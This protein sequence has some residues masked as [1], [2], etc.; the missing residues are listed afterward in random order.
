MTCT[1]ITTQQATDI[2][3]YI[4]I[5]IGR[6]LSCNNGTC[7]LYYHNRH[8]KSAIEMIIKVVAQCFD[9]LSISSIFIVKNKRNWFFICIFTSDLTRN[10]ISGVRKV[11]EDSTKVKNMLFR[12]IVAQCFDVP[13]MNSI[14]IEEIKKIDFF[15]FLHIS[16]I[17]SK[18]PYLGY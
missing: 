4:Y 6:L 13:S 9:I 11:V 16:Q 10:A 12:G 17:W 5:Y 1:V 7:H 3:I 15:D 8:N 18:W 2:Y 14:F